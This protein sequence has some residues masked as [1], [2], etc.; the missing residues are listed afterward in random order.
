VNFVCLPDL[1]E[2][3]GL[4]A[5]TGTDRAHLEGVVREMFEGEKLGFDAAKIDFSKVEEGWNS[6]VCYPHD[7]ST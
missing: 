5:D 4:G 6:N 3:S 1:Q 2:V 7:R